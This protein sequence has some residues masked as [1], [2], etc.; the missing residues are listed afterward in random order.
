MNI[1]VSIQDLLSRR[2]R[3]EF[4]NLGQITAIRLYEQMTEDAKKRCE[5]CEGEGTVVCGTCNGSGERAQRPPDK[6]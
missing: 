6:P 1:E 4:G 5:T 3:L 2:V